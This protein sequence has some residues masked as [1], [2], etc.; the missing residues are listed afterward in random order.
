MHIAFDMLIVEYELQEI[1]F[2]IRL[3]VHIITTIYRT[4]TY[5]I[6]TSC[7][8]EYEQYRRMTNVSIYPVKVSS[9][10]HMLI[11]HQL[12]LTH[13]LRR[14]K[15]DMLHVFGC[16]APIG[17]QGAYILMVYHQAL[18]VNEHLFVQ[19][20][21]FFQRRLLRESLQRARFV[22]AC[23]QEI[24]RALVEDWG[25]EKQAIRA[26]ANYD[27]Q[28][29]ITR[30]GQVYAEMQAMLFTSSSSATDI[31]YH[32][33]DALPSVSVIMPMTRLEKARQALQALSRQIY[34][35]DIEIIVVGVC[36]QRLCQE[37]ALCSIELDSQ[38]S[39][40]QA[41][42]IGAKRAK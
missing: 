13:A 29:I 28:K 6:I 34:A 22:I 18:L 26:V 23:S 4:Y 8:K 32:Q 35:G 2:S 17:W 41:R 14:I 40:G 15:P 9:R 16:V 20:A 21:K 12:L 31:S 19:L 11:Q 3:L 7:P 25:L 38:I 10:Y 27:Q 5:T 37:F 36:A 39:A 24:Q 1:L 42:N 33:Y 30:I